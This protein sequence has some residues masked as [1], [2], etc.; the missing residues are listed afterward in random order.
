VTSIDS[1]LAMCWCGK[2]SDPER[3]DP[4]VNIERLLVDYA[5]KELAE[6]KCM[7]RLRKN[8]K[9]KF[10]VNWGYLDISHRVISFEPFL[11]GLMC[12]LKKEK[13]QFSDVIKRDLC[14]FRTEFKNESNEAQNFTFK[15]E[16]TTTSRCDVTILQGFRL[17]ANLDVKISIPPVGSTFYI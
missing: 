6:P 1:V 3:G 17:G 7:D 10:E 13:K 11:E 14:L 5:W 8:R 12:P 2:T 16:R 9:F 15:T 4:V